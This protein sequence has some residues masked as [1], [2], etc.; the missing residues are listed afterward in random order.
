MRLQRPDDTPFDKTPTGM[1]RKGRGGG[2]AGSGLGDRE[3]LHLQEGVEVGDDSGFHDVLHSVVASSGGTALVTA[4]LVSRV[5]VT[6]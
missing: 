2:V 4:L 1:V 6:G 5:R 3:V